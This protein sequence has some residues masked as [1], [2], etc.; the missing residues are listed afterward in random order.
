MGRD[1]RDGGYGGGGGRGRGRDDNGGGAYGGR[2]RD[3]MPISNFVDRPPL[4]WKELET[5]RHGGIQVE[6]QKADGVTKTMYSLRVARPPRTEGQKSVP[7]IRP[8]D[9]DDAIAALE[10]CK[11][12]LGGNQGQGAGVVNAPAPTSDNDD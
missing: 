5:F 9:I 3:K 1:R 2:G 4:Q 8:E 6:L 11:R 10:A 12:W 7:Y